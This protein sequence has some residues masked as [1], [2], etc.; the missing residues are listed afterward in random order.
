MIDP[1]QHEVFTENL[2]TIFR[3]QINPEREIETELVEVTELRMS[4]A[5][6][7]FTVI[8]RGPNEVP[9]GQGMWNF[10]HDKMGEFSLF[11]VPI[12]RDDSGTSYEAVFN[13]VPRQTDPPVSV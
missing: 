11:V 7:R 10:A 12:S 9:L 8:F 5:Q 4:A 2:N 13:R 6:E 1:L 3:V